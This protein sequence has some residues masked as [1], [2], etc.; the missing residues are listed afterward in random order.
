[1]VKSDQSQYLKSGASASF[2]CVS[3]IEAGNTSLRASLPSNQV[4]GFA[5]F[6]ARD[7]F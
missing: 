1:M 5:F 2:F 6:S 7:D 3:T 4:R